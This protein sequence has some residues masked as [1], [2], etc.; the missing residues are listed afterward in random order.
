[1]REEITPKLDKLREEKRAFLEFQKKSSELEK[2]SRLVIAF[3]YFTF[4]TRKVKCLE[5]IKTAITS[6]TTSKTAKTRMEAEIKTMEK[7]VKEIEGRRQVEM[8]KGG[9]I[10]LLEI[11]QKELAKELAKD[12][13]RMEIIEETI[14]EEKKKVVELE[15]GA[16]E[17][18]PF[19]LNFGMITEEMNSS[20]IK[21][22][23]KSL[24]RKNP[25]ILLLL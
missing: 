21:K 3:D 10:G 15:L 7:D 13:T 23:P 22:L 16:K 24:R 20:P 18:C 11:Q 5:L 25:L 1:M 8:A 14:E 2:L 4:S 19:S 17:V 12:K 9:K 6:I